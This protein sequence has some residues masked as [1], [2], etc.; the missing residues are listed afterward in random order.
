MTAWTSAQALVSMVIEA[1]HEAHAL[2][3]GWAVARAMGGA[4]SAL[5]EAEPAA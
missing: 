3:A 4:R 1:P 2:S 5:V